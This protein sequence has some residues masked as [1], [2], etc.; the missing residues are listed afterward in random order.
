MD[1]LQDYIENSN[2]FKKFE[3]NNLLFAEFKCPIEDSKSRIWW[4]NNFFAFI[5]SGE[6]KLQ[7]STGTYILKA[8][9]CAFAKK[10]SVII[11]SQLQEDFCE[12]LIFI[13]D[14]FI[15]N[16]VDKHKLTL[17]VSK[18]RSYSDTII[19]I[20]KDKLISTYF[21]SLL[22]YFDLPTIPPKSAIALKFEELLLNLLSGNSHLSLKGYFHEVCASSRPSIKSIMEANFTQNLSIAEYAGMC[23]RSNSTFKS[24]F[25]Q[26]FGTSPGKW[27]L[28]KRLEHSLYLLENTD[29]TIS[30][31]AYASGFENISH[32]IKVF[33]NKFG[34]T[35]G[36]IK[37][38]TPSS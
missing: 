18:N 26:L 36:K 16:I 12:L 14:N 35:P 37:N 31:I 17:S 23:S 22:M 9:D 38:S 33:K 7:T 21:R 5:V 10:G 6:T 2:I 15:K 4:K 8:G 30:E 25:K 29:M 34:S 27:L 20:A 3:V 32:F 13:P 19:P 28:K 11:H 1:N 24:E